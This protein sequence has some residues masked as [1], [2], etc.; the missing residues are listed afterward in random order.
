MQ[1]RFSEVG[2][3]EGAVGCAM[4]HDIFAEYL[5]EE[6][7]L[8]HAARSSTLPV[9]LE[10]GLATFLGG[11]GASQSS[12]EAL[13]SAIEGDEGLS[14]DFSYQRASEFVQ[15]LVQL[16]GFEKIIEL[17]ELTDYESRFS[18]WRPHFEEVYGQTWEDVW[19]S[20]LESP[21]CF[22]DATMNDDV[23]LCHI[24]D[25]PVIEISSATTELEYLQDMECGEVGVVGPLKG[26]MLRH[27]IAVEFDFDVPT[28]VFARILGDVVPGSRVKVT[29]CGPCGQQEGFVLDDLN[30]F[31]LMSLQGRYV[32]ELRQPADAGGQLGIGLKP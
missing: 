27:E 6:H 7:E 16:G 11:T 30:G 13:R 3:V 20:Y 17:S 1:E 24:D 9:V 19:A 25:V 31:T 32:L 18:T 15:F 2:C 14:F 12:R 5:A 4:G 28:S 26:D 23:W 29:R 22:P 8:I 10:E 21:E